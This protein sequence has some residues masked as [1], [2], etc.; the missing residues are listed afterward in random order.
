MFRAPLYAGICRP[1]LELPKTRNSTAETTVGQ[2]RRNCYHCKKVS[3]FQAEFRG[4]TLG[5]FETP[6]GPAQARRLLDLRHMAP[7]T[8]VVTKTE[9]TAQRGW[10]GHLGNAPFYGVHKN[11]NNASGKPFFFVNLSLTFF[12][13]VSLLRGPF[14]SEP[15][16][17]P[18][19]RYTPTFTE[20]LVLITTHAHQSGRFSVYTV[21]HCYYYLCA[22]APV[23]RRCRLHMGVR[24]SLY[25]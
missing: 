12:F 4:Q 7:G 23:Y 13:L 9:R 17:D 5:C 14:P 6:R 2:T 22:R 21:A 19:I 16:V 10:I 8:T 18:K 20:N 1:K 3:A 24:G 15:K 11:R 25:L